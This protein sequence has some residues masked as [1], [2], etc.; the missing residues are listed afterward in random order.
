[1]KKM[2]LTEY[3]KSHEGRSEQLKRGW[4]I[5]HEKRKSDYT[6]DELLLMGCD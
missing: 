5:W 4:E 3:L 2:K 6:E 1:M